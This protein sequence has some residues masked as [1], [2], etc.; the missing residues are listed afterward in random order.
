MLAFAQSI[1]FTTAVAGYFPGTRLG[2]AGREASR[3]MR[4]WSRTCVRGD[5]RLADFGTEL[6]DALRRYTGRV[7]AIR[8]SHDALAPPGS[9]DRL[10]ALAPDA[11]WNVID[12]GADRFEKRRPDHF[13]WL[14]EPA[15]L[16]DAFA[17]LAQGTAA[18]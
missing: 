4:E 11:A 17:A 15:P 1:P 12:F 7:M 13:G 8:L 3:L 16:A 14:R 10:R 6:D 18:P 2:F 9:I 5:Y